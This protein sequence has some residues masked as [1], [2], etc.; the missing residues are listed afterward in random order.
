MNDITQMNHT[1]A[2]FLGA[3]YVTDE[4]SSQ[5]RY[6]K[7][8]RNIRAF[9]DHATQLKF[10]KSWEWIIPVYR[11]LDRM[12][13]TDVFILN[14][15]DV[16]KDSL[17]RGDIDRLHTS[18]HDLIVEHNK[19]KSNSTVEHA[20]SHFNLSKKRLVEA[21][22][23]IES[24]ATHAMEMDHNLFTETERELNKSISKIYRMAHISRL[25]KCFDNH[26]E[27]EEEFRN[28]VDRLVY[29]E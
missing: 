16:V 22:L 29:D 12:G 2:Y 18:I 7:P 24:I 23:I 8:N 14:N 9:L 20:L 15:L 28:T 19:N 21:I 25:P 11:V 17:L 13:E 5:W 6:S 27:W 3:E 4:E 1:I 10:H 26:D